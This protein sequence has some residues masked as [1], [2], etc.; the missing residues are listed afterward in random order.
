MPSYTL[1]PYREI[2]AVDFEFGCGDGERP[3]PRCM[4]ARELRTGKLLRLWAEELQALDGPPFA[5]DPQA[6]YVAYYASAELGCH[7][8]LSWPMPNRVLDLFAE[9]KCLTSG[10]E[11]P[12]GRSLVGAL[13]YFGL[14][15]IDVA[16]KDGMRQLAIRGGEYSDAERLALLDYCQTDADALA[17]LLPAM[18][19]KIDLPRALLRGR[20]MAA[21]ARIE[22]TGVPIDAATLGRLRRHWPAIKSRLV[23]AVDKD[24][25]VYVP[26]DA[27]RIDPGTTLGDAILRIAAEWDVDPCL[28]A[29]AL[30]YV[31]REEREGTAEHLQA[32]AAARK[33]T[34]LTV[35]RIAAWER[36]GRDCATWPALDV[37][38]RTL[39]RELPALGIGIGYEQE[40]VADDTD[41]AGG[42]WELLRDPERKTPP[43]HDSALLRR[44]AALVAAGN[45]DRYKSAKSLTFSAERFAAWLIRAGVPWPRLPSGSLA[46]DDSTFRAL[47]KAHPAVAP[48]REL[49]HTLGELR[50]ES[51]AV[52]R[53]GRNRCLLSAFGSKTGRNQPS[54][55][56]F[57]F[58]PSCWLRSLIQPAAGMAVAYVDWSQQEFGIAAALSGDTA[59]AAAY[60][61]GDPY[62]TFAKQAGAVPAN[63]TKQSHTKEREQFKICAL[64][65]QYG[66]AERSLAQ[67]IGQSEA[68]A[69]ELLRLH[70]QTYPAFWRW[71][72]AAV[73]HAMLH[74]WLRTVFGWRVHVGPDANP[75]SLANF[76]C[77]ANGADMLRLACCLATERGIK[78]CAP[79]HDALLIEAP[80]DEIERAV[81]G[82]Q[83]A[84]Q[85][86]S[87]VVLGGFALRTDA[88]I[89]VH[90]DRY[91]DPRGE[92]MWATVM[93]LLTELEAE[94]AALEAT[95]PW[96]P[97]PCLSF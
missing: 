60:S 86:A 21:A 7:L 11:V 15:C 90:P 58:G 71:S 73:N 75:R 16:E 40:A 74:G 25:G 19:P 38:A 29:E 62:L 79:V 4:V 77:Q 27:K 51:L 12:C 52:G 30:D 8:A 23:G 96:E 65:V 97:E 63:A 32:V 84:M 43:K 14:D 10:V 89:V 42:L 85:E 24:Y 39:A 69:R 44:A 50:L 82:C 46:L 41:Y 66:M 70:H 18:L 17:K 92:Q 48:L 56:R 26:T 61:S 1:A 36:S 37:Q 22:W 47:A 9:F 2:W 83:A 91:S 55:A 59:M 67:A 45:A 57:I 64:A 31:Y 93:G 87:E 88:K 28:V 35:A 76:P 54:N 68:H 5:I 20:Y 49:R 34:G 81:A 80:A 6:I 95:D 53:D 13:T 3:Q 33:A 94:Q 72:E 78:V